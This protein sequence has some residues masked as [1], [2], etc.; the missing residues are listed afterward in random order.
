MC[1][2][3]HVLQTMSQTNTL[4]TMPWKLFPNIV[5]KKMFTNRLN[6]GLILWAWIKKTVNGVETHKLS[7]KKVWCA[8]VSKEDN[9]EYSGTLKVTLLNF[10]KERKKNM[11]L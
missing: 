9:A 6:M 1:I 4:V 3:K 2:E 5:I 10:L 8:V 7:R 11:Q